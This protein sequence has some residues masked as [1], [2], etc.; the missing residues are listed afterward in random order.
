M[1]AVSVPTD[2]I[3]LAISPTDAQRRQTFGYVRSHRLRR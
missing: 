2:R 1:K 3:A